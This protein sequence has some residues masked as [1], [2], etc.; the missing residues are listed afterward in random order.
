VNEQLRLLIELQQLDSTILASRLKIDAIPSTIASHESLLK[1]AEAVY[2]SAKQTHAS[3]EKKKKDKEQEIEDIK[4]KSKKLT[5]RT[6]E[7]KTNKEYQAHLKEVEKTDKL[8]KTAEDELLSIID[9]IEGSSK[10]IEIEKNRIAEEKIKIDSI[11]EELQNEVHRCVEDIER[12]K[13]IRKNI[14]DKIDSDIYKEYMIVLKTR[15]GIA[16][17][18]AKDET[19]QGC[20]MNIPPQLFVEIKTSD[21]IIECPQCKRILYYA[22][23]EVTE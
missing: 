17:V 11:K 10:V 1:K 22:K 3:L 16:V 5:Q 7:I 13:G 12:L 2:E 4:E 9:S 15:L 21:E 23:A 14:V 18:E 20:N 6:S 19:C 8:L